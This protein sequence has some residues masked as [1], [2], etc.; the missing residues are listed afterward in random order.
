MNTQAKKHTNII[1]LDL[2]TQKN[3][4]QVGGWENADQML[5]SVA[6]IYDS[7]IGDYLHYTENEI[8]RLIHALSEASLVVGFNLKRF[9]YRVLSRYTNTDLQNLRTFDM[10]THI[11]NLLGFRVSL[12][13][14]AHATLKREK[15]G[16]GLEAIDL[17]NNG[18]LDELTKYCTT[19]VEIARELFIAGCKNGELFY[20]DR[21]GGRYA[22][23]TEY[24]SRE[25]KMLL[26]MQSHNQ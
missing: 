20:T 7:K 11:H 26:A 22:I 17:W 24:W 6:C 12:D 5:V 9:D 13:N 4:E 25:V 8:P 16:T 1:Y 19:D 18:K 15:T 14:L 10:L 3:A 2:E 23:K 21:D